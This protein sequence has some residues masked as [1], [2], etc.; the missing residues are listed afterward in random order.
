MIRS[1]LFLALSAGSVFAAPVVKTEHVE[2]E[3]VAEKSAVQAGRPVT[4]G[5]KLR[6]EPQWHTYWKNPG[7]SG[8][9]T[10]IQWILPAGWKAGPIQWPYPSQLPVGPLMNYGYE[11]D[12]VLLS[13]LTPPANVAP[14]T[15]DIKAKA[16]WLVC[17][18]I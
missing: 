5:L 10:R 17:K 9:P 3:L 11:D 8:L 1:L 4:L 7:D 12:I 18:D 14:G 16:E 15:A 13:E 2:A 6:M